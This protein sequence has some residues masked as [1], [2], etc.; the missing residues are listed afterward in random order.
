ML[1]VLCSALRT[2]CT[3]LTRSGTLQRPPSSLLRLINPISTR[4]LH[5]DHFLFPTLHLRPFAHKS[6]SA[7]PVGTPVP[8]SDLEKLPSTRRLLDWVKESPRKGSRSV[9]VVKRRDDDEEGEW[10][11]EVYLQDFAA[12]EGSE[13]RAGNLVGKGRSEFADDATTEY[14]FPCSF[15]DVT[16]ISAD[17]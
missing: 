7:D 8:K 16:S 14:V 9:E 1:S 3:T 12:V 15:S 11:C 6:S 17:S 5:H 13:L 4:P 2:S 10:V